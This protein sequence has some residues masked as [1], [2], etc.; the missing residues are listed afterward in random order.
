M[1]LLQTVEQAASRLETALKFANKY[2]EKLHDFGQLFPDSLRFIF[3]IQTW[4]DRQ[5]V[6]EKIGEIFGIYDWTQDPADRTNWIKTVDGVEVRIANA[7]THIT[8]ET[9][10]INPSSFHVAETV[11][12]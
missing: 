5:K 6:L 7:G 4:D 10:S 11:N 3:S 9:V 8:P 1:T 12:A 2:G